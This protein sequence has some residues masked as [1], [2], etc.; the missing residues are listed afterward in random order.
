[1]DIKRY[2]DS[3]INTIEGQ[4]SGASAALLAK[5]REKQVQEYEEQKRK[6]KEQNSFGL[7]RLD[8]KFSTNES[9]IEDH[10]GILTAEELRKKALS[11]TIKEQNEKQ[12][13]LD[14]GEKKL[15]KE[16]KRKKIQASLSFGDDEE[17]DNIDDD[18]IE[19]KKKRTKNPSVDTSFLPDANRD[20]ELEEQKQKLREDWIKQQEVIKNEVIQV[21][22]AYY[23]GSGHRG[24]CTIKKG[25][26]IGKFLETAKSDLSKEFHELRMT[27][28]DSLLYVKEDLIIPHHFTFYDLIVTKARG[29]SGPLFHFDVHD[30]V[31]L[32]HDHRIEKDE[33]HAGKIIERKYFER[34][35]HVFPLSRYEL[36]DPNKT[37]DKYTTHGGEVHS[38]K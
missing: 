25:S 13:E 30:D 17:F 37:Y 8:D 14:E 34:N 9:S 29:K 32:V 24:R 26:T 4:V 19:L 36:Y 23:D 12:I 22:Y 6:I 38:K 5:E 20:K 7:G 28:S 35:K 2:G 15:L 3:G 31:R 27:S 10:Y 16:Q 1:M 33:S 21:E 18:Q 11:K